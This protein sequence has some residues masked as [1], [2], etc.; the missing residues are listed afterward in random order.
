[1]MLFKVVVLITSLEF[2]IEGGGRNEYPY[3]TGYCCMYS[4]IDWN[5]SC[6]K[7]A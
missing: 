6:H 1:M 3:Y 5:A 4:C 7:N 2:W